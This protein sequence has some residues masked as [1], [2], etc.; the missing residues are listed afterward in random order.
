MVV[1]DDEFLDEVQLGHQPCGH[2]ANLR[3]AWLLTR[4]LPLGD[5]T[6]SMCRAIE[7]RAARLGG[8]VDRDLT[9]RWTALVARAA[10]ATSSPSF[11]TFLV[12]HQHLLV[13]TADRVA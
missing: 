10:A 5:A 9:A 3:L 4:R 2:L 7:Q 11:D 13:R 8:H 6:D 1:S 12:D